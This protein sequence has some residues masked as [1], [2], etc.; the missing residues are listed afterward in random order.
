MVK[1]FF[2][3]S[4]GNQSAFKNIIIKTISG[5]VRNRIVIVYLAVD[6]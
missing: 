1:V 4:F 3:S 5:G 2:H 6:K